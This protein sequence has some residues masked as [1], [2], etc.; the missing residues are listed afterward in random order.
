M[1]TNPQTVSGYPVFKRVAS[2]SDSLWF[3]ATGAGLPCSWMAQVLV[4]LK[5]AVSWQSV[6][7][8]CSSSSHLAL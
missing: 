6:F 2:I 3:G 5:L 8:C 1:A 7:E 4:W